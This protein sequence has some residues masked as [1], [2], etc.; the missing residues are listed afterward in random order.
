MKHE[1]SC[2]AVVFTVK[3]GAVKYLLI[4][5]I[6]GAVGFPKGHMETGESEIET[7]LREVREEVGLE[8]TLIEG[9]RTEEEYLIYAENCIKKKVVYFLGRY[10]NQDFAY[11]RDELSDAF[12]VDYATAMELCKF[13]STKRILT[14]ANDF[15]TQ[16]Y[17]GL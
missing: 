2:G 4:K 5:S 7:A 13:N 12:L 15:L 9:F 10:D 17:D 14:E 11:Q 16:S 1:K 3:D 6:R 8:I